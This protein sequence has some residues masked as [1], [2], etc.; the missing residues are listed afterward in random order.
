MAN[1]KEL[2]TYEAAIDDRLLKK[3]QRHHFMETAL[4]NISELSDPGQ[5]IATDYASLVVTSSRLPLGIGNTRTFAMEYYDMEFPEGRVIA[6]NTP[7]KLTLSLSGIISSS[8]LSRYIM[9]GPAGSSNSVVSG[10]AD[11]EPVRAL[12]VVMASHPNKDPSVYQGGQNKFF[13]YPV[14]Q[15]SWANYEL[16]GGLIAVRGYYSSIRLSTARILLN[17]HTQCSP[18]YKSIN[19]RELMQLFRELVPSDWLALERFLKGLRVETALMKTPEESPISKARTI[20]GL[21]YKMVQH[22]GSEKGS[23][24][25]EMD[26][27]NAKEVKFKRFG[28]PSG[29]PISVQD[30]FHTG[31]LPI[32]ISW[33]GTDASLEYRLTLSHP[34]EYVINCGMYSEPTIGVHA[35]HVI[36]RDIGP[37]SLD[38]S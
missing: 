4:K 37:S 33:V 9:S 13:R 6:K 16:R 26:H 34:T 31:K 2:F 10:P 22:A 32:A 23:G 30:F 5:G 27:G 38:T 29:I 19:V 24:N 3:Y 18:F 21:S 17:L 36:F 8:D 14:N 11:V 28:H 25:A 12:N 1:A 15:G 35:D 20:V 7:F